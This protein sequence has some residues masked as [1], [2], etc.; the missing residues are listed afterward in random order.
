MGETELSS[1]ILLSW[2]HAAGEGARLGEENILVCYEQIV[3][4]LCLCLKLQAGGSVVME[5]HTCRGEDKR[6]SPPHHHLHITPAT[7]THTHP[8]GHND[9]QTGLLTGTPLCVS[10][11]LGKTSPHF[12]EQITATACLSLSDI[13]SL[14]RT[15]AVKPRFSSQDPMMDVSRI[16]SHRFVL[17]LQ[18]A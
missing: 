3:S 1:L 12:A 6:G 8:S 7:H 4:L 18:Q 15:A 13:T 14:E 9:K 17:P 5:T 10:Q 11:L 2:A 16:S